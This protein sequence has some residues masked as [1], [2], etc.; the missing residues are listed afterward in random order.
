M[1]GP[2]LTRRKV[3]AKAARPV[4]QAGHTPQ[5]WL[6]SGHIQWVALVLYGSGQ[7]WHLD[8]GT[9]AGGR[10]S[11]SL[12]PASPL[13]HLVLLGKQPQG[14]VR[15]EG[16]PLHSLSATEVGGWGSPPQWRVEP[17]KVSD[18]IPPSPSP[19][20]AGGAWQRW[21]RMGG[22]PEVSYGLAPV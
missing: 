7:A 18:P 21:V 20:G 16:S 12:E 9:S 2:Q 8:A 10:C 13:G 14:S 17:E 5:L 19:G 11:P 1:M 6:L 15:W 22:V 4:L 3:K